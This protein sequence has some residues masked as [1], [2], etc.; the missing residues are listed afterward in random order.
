MKKL[1]TVCENFIK[2]LVGALLAAMV[3]IVFWNVVSRYFLGASIAW[4]E[5]ISR[6][7]LIWVVFLGAVLAYVKDEHL[8]LDILIKAVPK[9]IAHIMQVMADIGVLYAI[10]I[11]VMGGLNLTMTSWDWLSPAAAIPYAYVYLIIP[12]AGAAVLIMTIFKLIGHIKV[13]FGISKEEP[14]EDTQC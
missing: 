13:L 7:M 8:S 10:Y 2:Y 1:L 11:I 4:S 14:K 9:R 3:A 6:F 12:I 5:E